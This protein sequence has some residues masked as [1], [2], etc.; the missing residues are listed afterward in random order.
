MS[1]DSQAVADVTKSRRG[2]IT[3]LIAILLVIVAMVAVAY[4][5]GIGPFADLGKAQVTAPKPVPSTDND[6]DAEPTT[7]S[8]TLP[9]D[10]AQ[11]VMFW[12]Q[13][14]STEQVADLVADKFDSFELSE[15][16][17]N[18][19]T[20]DIRVKASYREGGELNGWLL[21]RKYNAEWYVT[22]ITRDGNPTTTPVNGQADMAV[23]KAIAEGNAANQEVPTG[24]L[25]GSWKVITVD[26][27]T[28]GSGTA[29]I[30]V[31]FSGGTA[32]DAKGQITC[33][34]KSINGVTHWFITGFSKS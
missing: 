23:A 9:S 26:K 19:T 16:A 12:E 28:A 22:M 33:I 27:V 18:A 31:A 5:M 21:L 34:S 11:E 13:V 17:E 32:P 1:D 25:D 29:M 10:E 4:A 2:V 7:P 20:A 24:F 3:A 30:E 14:A 15:I 6:E 8:V